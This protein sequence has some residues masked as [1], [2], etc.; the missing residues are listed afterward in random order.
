MVALMGLAQDNLLGE[1][2]N[3]IER[4]ERFLETSAEGREHATETLSIVEIDL[5]CIHDLI[6][7][8][9]EM[10]KAK[11]KGLRQSIGGMYMMSAAQALGQY[12]AEFNEQRRKGQR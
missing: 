10:R 2:A 4:A 8:I 1:P 5:N 9:P 7:E 3:Q 11:D 6:R 12:I